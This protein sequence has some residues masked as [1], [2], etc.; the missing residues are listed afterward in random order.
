MLFGK[1]SDMMQSNTPDWVV[2][3]VVGLCRRFNAT[4]L[5]CAYGVGHKENVRIRKLLNGRVAEFQYVN[6]MKQYPEWDPISLK[7]TLSRTFSIEEVFNK[8]KEKWYHFPVWE[9]FKPFAE[10]I[11]AEYAEYDPTYRRVR[12]DHK[13]TSPD[14]FLHVLNYATWAARIDNGV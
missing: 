3:D 10:D 14:D 9:E 11:L 6:T 8:I 7:Y 2:N 12:Y 4:F 5:G 13:A 1:K